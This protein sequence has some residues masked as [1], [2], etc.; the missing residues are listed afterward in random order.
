MCIRDRYI[1]AGTYT[2]YI[3]SSNTN[4]FRLRSGSGFTG[5]IVV[6][7]ISC[8]KVNGNAGMM[9]NMAS[10]DIVEDTP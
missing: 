4:A 8:K 6:K 2:E 10:G 3:K 7:D 9:T 1:S 5:T